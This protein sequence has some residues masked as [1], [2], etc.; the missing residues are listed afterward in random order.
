MP[1]RSNLNQQKSKTSFNLLLGTGIAFVVLGIVLLA[2]LATDIDLK[3]SSYRY[4]VLSI[5]GGI[6][7]FISIVKIKKKSIM[8]VGLFLIMTGSLLF[9]ISI[10]YVPYSLDRLWPVIVIFCGVSLLPSGIYIHKGI[11]ASYMIPSVAMVFLG[12]LCLM[13]SLDIIQEPFLQLASRWWPITL[14]MAGLCLV[15]LFF[16]R[17][18]HSIQLEDEEDDFKDL[19]D[20]N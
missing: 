13:F 1:E 19:D 15:I 7:L 10:N 4:L 16:I 3:P 11:R 5:L 8:F 9:F 14:I 20:R 2:T 17:N 12:F 18:K 6:L